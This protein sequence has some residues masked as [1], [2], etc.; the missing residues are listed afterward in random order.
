MSEIPADADQFS[1]R[2]EGGSRGCGRSGQIFNSVI[3]PIADPGDA[4]ENQVR[5]G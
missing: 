3:D 2:V 5:F 4:V 1:H